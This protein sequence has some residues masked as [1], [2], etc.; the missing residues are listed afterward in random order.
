MSGREFFASNSH[1]VRFP[2]GE[3]C[4]PDPKG[5]AGYVYQYQGQSHVTTS[6]EVKDK[7]SGVYA[8]IIA[9]VHDGSASVAVFGTANFLNTSK[10]TI[11]PQQTLAFIEHGTP[12]ELRAHIAP[13]LKQTLEDAG[14]PAVVIPE[15]MIAD[16]QLSG[17]STV[18]DELAAYTQ[19]TDPDAY[20]AALKKKSAEFGPEATHAKAVVKL[21]EAYR[22][23]RNGTIANV[24]E[25]HFREFFA[26]QQAFPTKVRPFGV[27][28]TAESA[29]KPG[30][31]GLVRIHWSLTMHPSP[32]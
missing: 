24:K 13:S 4:A 2:I 26:A 5:H 21:I 12:A 22:A 10:Y 30:E 3:G 27:N 23:I 1:N 9:Y 20:L 8:G 19:D 32:H 29:V 11:Q 15:M 14:L 25:A 18:V 7:Y 17:Q 6:L 31:F 28:I 16:L